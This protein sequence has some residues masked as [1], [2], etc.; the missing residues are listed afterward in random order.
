M[1]AAT[2]LCI[3]DTTETHPIY[4]SGLTVT[5]RLPT[6]VDEQELSVLASGLNRAESIEP[7]DFETVGS[8]CVDDPPGLAHVQFWPSH[9]WRTSMTAGIAAAV[10]KRATWAA[11]R[12]E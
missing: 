12:L 8:W 5:L 11:N 2:G 3:F 7:H 10:A 4:G 1:M 6:Q 9:L